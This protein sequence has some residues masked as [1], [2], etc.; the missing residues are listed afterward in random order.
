M[1]RNYARC[2]EMGL[3]E[4]LRLQLRNQLC[5][6]PGFFS[7]CGYFTFFSLHKEKKKVT[8]RFD[9]KEEFYLKN[10]LEG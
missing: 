3:E 7:F 6:R 1:D 10:K 4:F 2:I 9:M 5:E 8:K